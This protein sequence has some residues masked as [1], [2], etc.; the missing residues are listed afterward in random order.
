[1]RKTNR[2]WPECNQFQRWPWYISMSTF[3]PFLPYVLKKIQETPNFNGFTKSKWRQ[4]EEYQHTVTKI[5]SVLKV[6]RIHQ[7]DKFEA[8]PP[9]R[10]QEIARKLQ[11]WSVSLSQ[12]AAKMRTVITR[13][14]KSNQFSRWSGY[15]S[16]MNFRPFT[17]TAIKIQ[18]R[19]QLHL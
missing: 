11:I 12:I 16:M 8:I 2:P 7:Q 15:I 10:S 1:M 5:E 17:V 3:R 9:L 6:V 18:V 14:P 19:N 13:S 4:N